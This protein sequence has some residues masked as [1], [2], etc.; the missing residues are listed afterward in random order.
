MYSFE[1]ILFSYSYHTTC[2]RL[3]LSSMME[4]P[5]DR[6]V[7]S[8]QACIRDLFPVKP[9]EISFWASLRARLYAQFCMLEMG[10]FCW[11]FPFSNAALFTPRWILL[12]SLDGHWVRF[13]RKYSKKGP[14]IFGHT[15]F[16]I[17]LLWKTYFLGKCRTLGLKDKR[18]TTHFPNHNLNSL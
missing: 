17:C 3:R 18:Q 5:R 12:R 6:L 2:T 10:E 16:F 14:N 4:V 9:T 15:V 1:N 11:H 13:L 8:I 7:I